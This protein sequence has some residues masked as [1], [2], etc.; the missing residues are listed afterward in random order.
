MP[1]IFA[2]ALLVS[3]GNFERQKQS[4]LG[5]YIAWH[6]TRGIEAIRLGGDFVMV[7]GAWYREPAII[8]AGLL[9]VLAAWTSGPLRRR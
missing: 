1:P 3:L 9:I 5:R 4:R 8:A 6:M 2:S 7:F